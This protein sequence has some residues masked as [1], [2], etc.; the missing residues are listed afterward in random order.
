METIGKRVAALKKQVGSRARELRKQAGFSSAE[1]AAEAMGVHSNTV[2]GLERG[3]IWI[4]PEMV[5]K[6]RDCYKFD[7]PALLFSI[8]TPKASPTPQEALEV[9]AKAISMKPSAAALPGTEDFDDQEIRMLQAAV[10]AIRSQR[11]FSSARKKREN[12][13]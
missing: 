8:S 3:D 4:S 10:D 1:A 12:H 7:E 9:L 13:S 11:E 6:M 2:A 5:M